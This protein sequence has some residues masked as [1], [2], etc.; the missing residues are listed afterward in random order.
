MPKPVPKRINPADVPAKALEIVANVKFPMLATIDGDQPRIR[1]VSPLLTRGFEVFIG[2]LRSYHKTIEIA[3][4]N[5]IELCYLDIDHNQVRITAVAEIVTDRELLQNIWN[6][7]SLLKHYLGSI[8][9]P[10]LIVYRC[11]P[12][13]VRFMQEWALDYIEVP[14]PEILS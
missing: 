12:G 7:N 9:N 10:D 8:D 6:K 5:R 11:K 13:R 3:A 4:N 1:P 14:I 2:N